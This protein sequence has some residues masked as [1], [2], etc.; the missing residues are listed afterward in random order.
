MTLPSCQSTHGLVIFFSLLLYSLACGF[1][2]LHSF[3]SLRSLFSFSSYLIRLSSHFPLFSL[4]IYNIH[5]GIYF[6]LSALSSVFY[7][8]FSLSS[9]TYFSTCLHPNTWS[10]PCVLSCLPCLLYCLPCPPCPV[11][12]FPVSLSLVEVHLVTFPQP[13]SICVAGGT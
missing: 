1:V 4:H 12:S 10:S 3:L 6:S 8:L 11:L 5:L 7:L 2:C 9:F 13:L